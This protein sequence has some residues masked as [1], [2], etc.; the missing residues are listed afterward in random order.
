MTL[1]GF[2]PFILSEVQGCPDPMVNQALIMAAI[3]FTRETLSWTELSDP[4]P[5]KDQEQDYEID[6]PSGSFLIT[7]RDVWIG[8]RRLIP[9]TLSQ[10]PMVLTDWQT[11]QSNAPTYYTQAIDRGSLRFYPMPLNPTETFTVRAAFAPLTSA[12]TVP[13]FIGQQYMDV[14]SSGAKSRL[15]LMPEK[16]WSNPTMGAYYKQQFADGVIKCRVLE[17]HDRV[18]GTITIKPRRFGF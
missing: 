1:D 7:V 16:P 15:M 12:T 11:S 13:D 4:Y 2:L 17:A 5:L 3:D 8:N 6:V 14:I 10:I 9:T 18:R